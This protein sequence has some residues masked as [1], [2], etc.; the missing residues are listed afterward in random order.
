MSKKHTP[1]EAPPG[2]PAETGFSYPPESQQ[3]LFTI[4]LT[5]LDN[6]PFK[7]TIKA[8]CWTVVDLHHVIDSYSFCYITPPPLVNIA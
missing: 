8:S 4:Q 3:C 7:G 2:D 5:L 6:W 1:R